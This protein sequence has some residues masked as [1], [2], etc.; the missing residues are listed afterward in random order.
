MKRRYVTPRR[1]QRIGESAWIFKLLVFLPFFLSRTEG[2]SA[3]RNVR[4]RAA[5]TCSCRAVRSTTSPTAPPMISPRPCLARSRRRCD[6]VLFAHYVSRLLLSL[7]HFQAIHLLLAYPFISC[8]ILLSFLV[9]FRPPPVSYSLSARL[10]LSP[11]PSSFPPFFLY[12]LPLLSSAASLPPSLHLSFPV[13]FLPLFVPSLPFLHF[14]HVCLSLRLPSLHLRLSSGLR[15]FL[16]RCHSFSLRLLLSP[17]PSAPLAFLRCFPSFLP[18]YYLPSILSAVA[19]VVLVLPPFLPCLLILPSII[20]ASSPLAFPLILPSLISLFA[21]LAILR[22][23]SSP[24]PSSCLP[25]L[26]S[27]VVRSAPAVPLFLPSLPVLAS[28]F[29]ALISIAPLLAPCPPVLCP[30]LT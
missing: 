2:S 28:H 16:T 20:P 3:R 9:L 5:C 11:F 15:S 30:S 19:R 6:C 21:P 13:S 18:S 14:F 29:P 22:C 10:L 12:A 1:F 25:F 27:A 23:F 24:L 4:D 7:P 26:L 8:I 17:F